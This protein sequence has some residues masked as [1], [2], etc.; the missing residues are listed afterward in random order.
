MSPALPKGETNGIDVIA[1]QLVNEPETVHVI[2]A[3]VDCSK[4]TTDVDTGATVPTARIRAVEAFP[5]KTADAA[6]I[7]RLWRRA[8]ERRTRTDQ[9]ELPLEL[10][11]ALD[12]LEPAEPDQPGPTAADTQDGDPE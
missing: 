8:L 3:L 9:T 7:R 6:E 5:G 11:Q 12:A 2:V 4:M 10:E 1:A